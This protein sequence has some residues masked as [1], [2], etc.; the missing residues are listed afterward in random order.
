MMMGAGVLISFHELEENE[1]EVQLQG[2]RV[3]HEL[4]DATV[5]LMNIHDSEIVFGRVKEGMNQVI[6]NQ[7]IPIMQGLYEAYRMLEQE[8]RRMNDESRTHFREVYR[9]GII[10]EFAIEN[11]SGSGFGFQGLR[12]YA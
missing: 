2:R 4:R 7:H 10:W 3:R 1:T 12:Q 6:L 11:I 5:G 9:D 8:V